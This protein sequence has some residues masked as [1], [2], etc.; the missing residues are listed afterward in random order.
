MM[1]WRLARI[2]QEIVETTPTRCS[3]QS[4]LQLMF[5][6]AL[7]GSAHQSFFRFYF[8]PCAEG[9]NRKIPTNTQN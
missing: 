1:E 8:R 4:S 9:V 3:L 2:E 5:A 6:F 7:C